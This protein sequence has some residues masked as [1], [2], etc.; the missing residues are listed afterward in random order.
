MVVYHVSRMTPQSVN[1]IKYRT[2]AYEENLQQLTCDCH[3]TAL[4]GI[5]CRHILRV[6]TQLNLEQLPTH[7]F[8]IRWCKDPSDEQMV[9]QYKLF[10]SS[11][12]RDNE[13]QTEGFYM[14]TEHEDFQLFMLGKTMRKIER[15]A[16]YNPGTAKV[17]HGELNK[18]LETNVASIEP[19]SS[20][21]H[22]RNPLVVST[23][24]PKKKISKKG[25]TSKEKGG[26]TV[27]KVTCGTCGRQGH[28][29]RSKHCPGRPVSDSD[30]TVTGERYDPSDIT[31][32]QGNVN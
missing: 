4:T 5:P 26:V 11:Q 30:E 9:E 18:V 6:S 13:K 19:Q 25:D 12:A 17:L 27:R 29:S 10:F 14:P 22:I 1:T 21:A 8:P 7:L 15:F 2:V 31:E 16:K 20:N 24:G 3:Q 28:T 32:L 23:K